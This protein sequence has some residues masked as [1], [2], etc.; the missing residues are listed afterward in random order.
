MY[1][2]NNY[3]NQGIVGA[4]PG[5]SNWETDSNNLSVGC[6]NV[7]AYRG[8]GEE[9]RHSFFPSTQAVHNHYNYNQSERENPRF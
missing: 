6:S 9:Q 5:N 8:Y 3:F 7:A 4:F 2:N 1:N